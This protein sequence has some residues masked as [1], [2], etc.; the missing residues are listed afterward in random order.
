M[1]RQFRT[2]LAMILL[3]TV[4]TGGVY[5]LAVTVV[6]GIIFPHQAQGSLIRRDGRVLGSELI[7]QQFTRAE[8]FHPRPSAAGAGYDPLQSGGSNLGPTNPLLIERVRQE[9]DRLRR[10]NVC[11]APPVDLVTTS[12][13]GLDPHVS[14][15][16]ADLQVARVAR[17]RGLPEEAVRH[18]LALHLEKRQFGLLG[19]PR[20]NVLRLNMALDTLQRPAQ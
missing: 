19:E 7:G 16:S 5:P 9:V 18:A 6:A 11:E 4:L 8:Y 10:L 17:A 1:L 2:A 15:A 12:G 13:S 3:L 20:V 14:P